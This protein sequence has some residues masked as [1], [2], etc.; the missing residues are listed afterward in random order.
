[1]NINNLN[2][3]IGQN[4]RLGEIECINIGI[5]QL[6]KLDNLKFFQ[7]QNIAEKLNKGLI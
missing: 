2:N 1:M 5:E 7:K 6:K 3:I 4:Y